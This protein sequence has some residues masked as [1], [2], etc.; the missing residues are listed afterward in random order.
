MRDPVQSVTWRTL[1]SFFLVALVIGSGIFI[2]RHGWRIERGSPDRAAFGSGPTDNAVTL[3]MTQGNLCET[4][5]REPFETVLF[6]T[7]DLTVFSF[8]TQEAARIGVSSPTIVE[9]IMQAGYDVKDIAVVVHNHFTPAGFTDADKATY[10]YLKGRGFTGAF[11]IWY[12]A[13]KRFER[14]KETG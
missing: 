7:Y 4:Y 2:I 6:V 9:R 3:Y 5:F 10:Q 14:I 11:G 13:T 8:S 1:S 12:T